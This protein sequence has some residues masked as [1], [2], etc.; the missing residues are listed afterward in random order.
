MLQIRHWGR[1]RLSDVGCTYRAVRK[2]ALRKI[3]PELREGGN[4]FSPHMILVALGSGLT[5]IEVPVTF[6]HRIGESKGVG[7]Q[8]LKGLAVGLRMLWMIFMQ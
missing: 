8:K 2:D 3:M 5:V 7:K 6:R 1:V 4:A